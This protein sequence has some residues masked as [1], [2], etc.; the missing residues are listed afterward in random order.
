MGQSPNS[1]R[2]AHPAARHRRA[3]CR[4]AEIETGGKLLREMQAMASIAWFTISPGWP[5]SSGSARSLNFSIHGTRSVVAAISR[6][7]TA[8]LCGSSRQR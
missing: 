1:A 3:R 8:L 7:L 4:R 2:P 6:G 5:T